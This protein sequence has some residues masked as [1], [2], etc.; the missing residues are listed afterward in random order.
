MEKLL[1]WIER[2]KPG[3]YKILNSTGRKIYEMSSE[4]LEVLTAELTDTYDSLDNGRYTIIASDA[5]NTPDVKSLQLSFTVG[6]DSNRGNMS[7]LSI[8][9]IE[10]R[11]Y[12]RAKTEFEYNYLNERLTKLEAKFDKLLMIVTEWKDEQDED[13]DKDVLTSVINTGEKLQTGFDML[14]SFKM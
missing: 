2:N 10:E 5:K 8:K 14:K 11:A 3:Y 6:G 13:E 9:E 4:S 1:T 7:G 12:N